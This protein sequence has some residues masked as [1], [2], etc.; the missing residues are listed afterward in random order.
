MITVKLSPPDLRSMTAYQQM[1]NM[2]RWWPLTASIRAK[3]FD[4]IEIKTVKN[5]SPDPRIIRINA[6]VNNSVLESAAKP[7]I[8]IGP[9]SGWKLLAWP[10]LRYVFPNQICTISQAIALTVHAPPA[11]AC[12]VNSKPEK[13]MAAMPMK[14]TNSAII[15]RS[16]LIDINTGNRNVPKELTKLQRYFWQRKKRAWENIKTCRQYAQKWTYRGNKIQAPQANMS[17]PKEDDHSVQ[18]INTTAQPWINEIY[19]H[20]SLGL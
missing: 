15:A 6:L 13:H 8:K 5:M 4:R 19:R 10:K 18:P 14:N 11:K 2:T 12:S 16:A 17:N 20:E 9:N 7:V 3:V 1:V